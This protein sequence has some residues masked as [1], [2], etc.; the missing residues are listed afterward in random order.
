MSNQQILIV[1]D[2]VFIAMG[3]Q[4]KLTA[5][6]Y[7]V[8]GIAESGEKA[9]LMAREHQPDLVLMDIV[10]KGDLDGIEVAERIR[11]QFNIPVIY[12]TAYGDDK[13]LHRAKV[14]EPFGY[15]LKP[16]NDHELAITIEISLYKY[17]ME[18]KLRDQQHWYSTIL[19]NLGEAVI[20]TDIHQTITFVNPA[21]EALFQIKAP[22]YLGRTI[23]QL[24]TNND[25]F[26]QNLFE[27]IKK[28]LEEKEPLR[29]F[30]LELTIEEERLIVDLCLTSIFTEGG[31]LIGCALVF[32][33][34]TAQA[35]MQ[36]T[37]QNQSIPDQAA[38]QVL[39]EL[40]T[41]R[42]KQILKHIVDGLTT[43]E[44]AYN[45]DISPRT[46]EFHRYNLMRKLN[47]QDIPSLVREAIANH[48]VT[49][50]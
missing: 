43:K 33:D 46:V 26:A 24:F 13:H 20:T 36:T 28:N 9:L 16:Y 19:K 38:N 48:L 27:M 25:A 44:I 1:E 31:K 45:F 50:T 30:H 18:K 23:D 10:I 40:L 41:A 2:E 11:E 3:L 14:T 22:S 34:Q 47:V 21:A 35:H 37:L 6:G 12:L 5:L 8:V 17:R 4:E 49:L 29:Q 15:L 42:E 39:L 7:I 32:Y